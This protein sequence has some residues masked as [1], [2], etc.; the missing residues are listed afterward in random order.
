MTSQIYAVITQTT[1]Q[2]SQ[3]TQDIIT[4]N[5]VSFSRPYSS[6]MTPVRLWI[7]FL[8]PRRTR[9]AVRFSLYRADATGRFNVSISR[10]LFLDG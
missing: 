2:C 9:A 1:V 4:A 8:I 10:E 7:A 3:L 5:D 6:D